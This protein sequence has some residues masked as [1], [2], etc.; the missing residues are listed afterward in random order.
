MAARLTTGLVQRLGGRPVP[1]D[2]PA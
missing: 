2:A 1:L